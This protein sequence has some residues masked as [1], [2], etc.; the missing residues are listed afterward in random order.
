[1]QH[2]NVSSEFEAMEGIEGLTGSGRYESFC[3]LFWV[4]FLAK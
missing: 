4:F 2:L 3:F 1:M